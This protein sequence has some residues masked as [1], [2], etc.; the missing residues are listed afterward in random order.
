MMSSRQLL[1]LD[2]SYAAMA[3][4][5]DRRKLIASIK[6]SLGPRVYACRPGEAFVKCAMWER[7]G[8][9]G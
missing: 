6:A 9:L 1:G 5:T 3:A 2:L 4:A 7:N 8:Q